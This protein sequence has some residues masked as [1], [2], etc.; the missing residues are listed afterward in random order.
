MT[1][2]N[3]DRHIYLPLVPPLCAPAC[4]PLPSPTHRVL[5]L[6]ALADM[7][8]DREDMR[9]LVDDILRGALAPDSSKKAG[10]GAST[11]PRRSARGSSAPPPPPPLTAADMR[12]R[13]PLGQD[14]DGNSYH[15]YDMPYDHDAPVGLMGSRLYVEGP[16]QRPGSTEQQPQQQAAVAG[17]EAQ[18]QQQQHQEGEESEHGLVKRE[19]DGGDAAD[20]KAPGKPPLP[21]AR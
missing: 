17:K 2:C 18:Q 13:K 6:K 1:L 14:A 8:A 3:P 10:S 9:L 19:T 11:P 12:G 15:W 4:S 16:P 7:R 21:P 5:T 20:G